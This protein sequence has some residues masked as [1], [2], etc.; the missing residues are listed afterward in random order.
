MDKVPFVT[1]N[2][3][4]EMRQLGF[5]VFLVPADEVVEPVRGALDAGY[6]LIDTATL[7]GNEEGVGRAIAESGIPRDD[8]FITTKV[9][10]SDQGYD[11]TLE[12]FDQSTKL[13]GLD[14]VDLYL[15]HWPSPE[16]DLYADTWRAL[17]RIYADGRARAIGVS[18]FHVSHLERILSE[19]TV[20]PAVNQVELHPGF[21]Q[22]ELRAFNEQHGI[23][24]EAWGPIGRGKGLLDR[25][26][27]RAIA[28]AHDKTPA[29]VVLRWHIQLGVIAIPK[30]V[31][32]ERI[33]ENLDIFDFELTRDDMAALSAL[34]G[35]GRLGA[36]PDAMNLA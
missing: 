22:D 29:Q 11:R 18:N 20:V 25:D 21:P 17:E 32:P 14:V 3:G 9:W 15:I 27:V 16:R 19:G 4:V 33:R 34:D 10:N 8:I 13:L 23:A 28:R 5:G 36:D 24:T 7:Y 35:P 2:N 6:R 12:A 31:R 1:L 26:E 30:S